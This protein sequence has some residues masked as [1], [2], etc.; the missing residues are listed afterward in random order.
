MNVFRHLYDYNLIK[1]K[2]FNKAY[3]IYIVINI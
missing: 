2:Y 3:K 1:I